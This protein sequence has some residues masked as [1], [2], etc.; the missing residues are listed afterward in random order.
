MKN[1][2]L[3]KPNDVNTEHAV[4]PVDLQGADRESSYIQQRNRKSQLAV[5]LGLAANIF[6][7]LLKTSVGILGHSPAL[8]AEG[9]NSTSD[10]AYYLVV[11]VFMRLSHKPADETHPYGH[12]QL[13][14][15]ASLVVGAFIVTTAIA[16]FWKAV[17]DVFELFTGNVQS[18]GASTLALYVAL[19]TVALKIYL[20]WYTRRLGRETNN[21]AVMAL[22]SDHRNDILS[23]SAAALGIFFGQRGFPWADPL[24]GALVA[25]L[26]LRTG[27]EILRQS[28]AELMDAVP[29]RALSRQINRL[30][31]SL[32]DVQ[33]VEEVHAHR[34]G[35]YLVVNLTIGIDGSQSVAAGD[36]IATQV[37]NLIYQHMD[38]VR[39]VYVHYH[40]VT[41]LETCET[42]VIEPSDLVE[43]DEQQR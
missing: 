4:R 3:K 10:V 22:V 36:C 18:E 1:Q 15:I 29:S 24:V 39:K 19:F 28:S 37:E 12:N 5:T 9:V 2:P 20:F 43:L 6:L 14:S 38:L 40:P 25:L 13:E 34:F 27:V 42:P 21:P 7:A 31:A 11:A 23:A 41:A 16:V 17:N 35:P 33:S 32:P 8:L 26:I 30:L